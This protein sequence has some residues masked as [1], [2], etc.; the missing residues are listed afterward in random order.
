MQIAQDILKRSQVEEGRI[1]AAM[2][3]EE[4]ANIENLLENTKGKSR[5]TH[6]LK[7]PYGTIHLEIKKKI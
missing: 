5:V 6:E 7:F 4:F 3:R 1:A 2:L